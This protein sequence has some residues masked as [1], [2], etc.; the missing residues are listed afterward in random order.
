MQSSNYKIIQDTVSVSGTERSVSSNYKL[1]DTAGE[2]AIGV[3]QSSNYKAH[4]GYRFLSDFVVS[5]STPTDVN[6]GSLSQSDKGTAGGSISWTVTTDNPSGYSLA[7]SASTK[8]ALKLGNGFFADYSP[9]GVT[10]I[11]SVDVA[12]SEFGFSV[13]ASGETDIANV[14]KNNGSSCGAGSDLGN[15]YQGF[16]GTN[17]IQIVSRDSAALSGN[18]T[19]VNLKLEIGHDKIQD[20]GAYSATITATA[21]AL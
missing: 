14:F 20:I 1:S 12:D 4:A 13:G 15:C 19:T 16:N 8:P 7:V 21:T 10:G 3:G 2:E 9:G 6:M 18:T 11:W 17:T 5:I